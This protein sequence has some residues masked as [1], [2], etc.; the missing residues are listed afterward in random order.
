MKGKLSMATL[1]E[2]DTSRVS[3]R[4]AKV[5]HTTPCPSLVWPTAPHSLKKA[6][7]PPASSP[8]R[9]HSLRRLSIVP[10]CRCN[11]VISSVSYRR[12]FGCCQSRVS[13]RATQHRNGVESDIMASQIVIYSIMKNVV[14]MA[15]C[16]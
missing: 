9:P 10:S 15:S 6:R 8:V 16:R 7:G 5:M 11:K 3:L 14:C 4:N 2:C 12:V 13:C 1:C